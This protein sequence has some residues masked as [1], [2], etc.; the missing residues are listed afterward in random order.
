MNVPSSA[1]GLPQPLSRKRVCPPPTLACGW[2]GGGDPIPTTGEKLSTLPVPTLCFWESPNPFHSWVMFK[3]RIL[4]TPLSVDPCHHLQRL[5][6]AE[7]SPSC[8]LTPWPGSNSILLPPL[9]FFLLCLR[10]NGRKRVK[11]RT[12]SHIQCDTCYIESTHTSADKND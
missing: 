8:R 4:F 6:E 12:S 7:M 5:W 3:C 2:R 11:N 10:K 1:L 9:L